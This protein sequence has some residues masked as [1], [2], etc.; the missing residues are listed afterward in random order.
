VPPTPEI[1]P[2]I[3]VPPPPGGVPPLKMTMTHSVAVIVARG[4][5]H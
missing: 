4:A 5:D 1:P 3:D 2:P